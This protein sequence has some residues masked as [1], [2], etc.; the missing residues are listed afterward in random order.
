MLGD[1]AGIDQERD[2]FF[3]GKVVGGGRE[4]GEIECE[5]ASDEV[6]GGFG[7]VTGVNPRSGY[8][9]NGW[10]CKGE[11]E[12]MGIGPAYSLESEFSKHKL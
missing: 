11:L 4:V 10:S 8:I 9:R 1:E 6:R 3:P 2:E 5:P 12:T 7:H